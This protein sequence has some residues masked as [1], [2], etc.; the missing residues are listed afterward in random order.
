MNTTTT[1]TTNKAVGDHDADDQSETGSIMTEQSSGYGSAIVRSSEVNL[2]FKSDLEE[3][4]ATFKN[5]PMEVNE[6]DYVSPMKLSADDAENDGGKGGGKDSDVDSGRADSASSDNPE[7]M[8]RAKI[9]SYGI[10]DKVRVL[11]DITIC[12]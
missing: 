12:D 9:A 1:T 7:R 10:Q 8:L 2:E 5:T 4:N 3:F 6:D 11:N